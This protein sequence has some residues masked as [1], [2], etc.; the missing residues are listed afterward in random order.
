MV[1]VALGLAWSKPV[2]AQR[3]TGNRVVSGKVL[4]RQDAPVPGAVVYLTNT[5]TRAIRTYIVK[6]DGGYRFPGLASNTDYELYAQ[7]GDKKS[8]TKTMSQF[9]DREQVTINLKM[10]MR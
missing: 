6:D 9:D 1:L 10:D 2:V 8:D 5:R 4:D 7:H 3:G